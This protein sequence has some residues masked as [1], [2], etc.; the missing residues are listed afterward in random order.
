MSNVTLYGPPQSSYV[1]TAR[2]VCEEKG[3]V[4]ELAPLNLGS[5]EHVALHP[6]GRVPVLKHGDF[7]LNETSAIARYL[8]ES[9]PGA[10]LVP[11]TAVE[12]A[13][14]EQWISTINAYFYGDLIRGYVLPY[15]FP[16]G[17]EGKPDRAAIEAALPNVKRD[18]QVLDKHLERSE[19][20]AGST[21]SLA[22]LFAAPI[23]FYVGM[24][25]E[26]SE[27]MSGLKNMRRCGGALMARESFK[28]T[29]PPRPA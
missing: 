13:R 14:M 9:F 18:L 16:K 21:L 23:L 12:R 6:F 29:M 20:L 17:P 1:R 2:M 3:I 15:I 26:G 22:D 10:S 5:E 27:I 24:F 19:W 11:G 4:Y 28:K 8:D 7:H 25:P